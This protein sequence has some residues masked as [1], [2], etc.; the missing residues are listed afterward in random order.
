MLAHAVVVHFA[1]SAPCN[2]LASPAARHT[3][4]PVTRVKISDDSPNS[5]L[6]GAL[7]PSRPALDPSQPAAL[8]VGQPAVLPAGQRRSMLACKRHT[9]SVEW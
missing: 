2:T 8:D 3:G 4:K 7:D 9:T 6:L 5:L 1:P